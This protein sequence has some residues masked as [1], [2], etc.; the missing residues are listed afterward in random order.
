MVS[1]DYK[2]GQNCNETGVIG[3][4]LEGVYRGHMC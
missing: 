2:K 1:E 4:K 3:R